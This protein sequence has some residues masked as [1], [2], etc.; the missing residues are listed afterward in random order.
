MINLIKTK[1]NQKRKQQI[2]QNEIKIKNNEIEKLEQQLITQKQEQNR[3]EKQSDSVNRNT[4]TKYPLSFLSDPIDIFITESN[5]QERQEISGVG[6][7]P[8]RKISGKNVC[9]CRCSCENRWSVSPQ[10][11]EE[12]RETETSDDDDS[13]G[14]KI[15][16]LEDLY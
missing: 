9:T 10:G 14:H 4:K 15:F 2:R 5:D 11:T 8:R 7:N 16:A 6:I 3:V 1:Q 13:R 12:E